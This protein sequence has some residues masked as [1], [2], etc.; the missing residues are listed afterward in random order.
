MTSA[1]PAAV[2]VHW[3]AA[4]SGRGLGPPARRAGGWS[5]RLA[6]PSLSLR[7]A[8]PPTRTDARLYPHTSVLLKF[9]DSILSHER[10]KQ[11]HDYTEQLFVN[12]QKLPHRIRHLAAHRLGREAAARRL[13]SQKISINQRGLRKR[14]RRPKGCSFAIGA[15]RR[16]R[17]H[18]AG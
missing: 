7:S 1:G 12:D 10:H 2:Q 18:F 8:G 16:F 9:F 13:E 17:L 6:S 4:G 11:N 5:L 15:H 3:L 14:V